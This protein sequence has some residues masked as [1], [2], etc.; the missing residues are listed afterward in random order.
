[1]IYN[2]KQIQLS[3]VL[4]YIVFITTWQHLLLKYFILVFCLSTFASAALLSCRGF[5]SVSHL[6]FFPLFYTVFPR[7]KWQKMQFMLQKIPSVIFYRGSN[8]R[9]RSSTS[10][11]A[12]HSSRRRCYPLPSSGQIFR[13]RNPRN[14]E[15]LERPPIFA[16]FPA[17]LQGVNMVK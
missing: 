9:I 7:C 3:I 12:R 8:R 2:R 10:A 1:M 13:S 6:F 4:H 5:I 15:T 14:R 17:L 16:Y 11:I